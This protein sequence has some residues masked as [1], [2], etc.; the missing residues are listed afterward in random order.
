LQRRNA[1]AI[2]FQ[3]PMIQQVA[4]VAVRTPFWDEAPLSREGFMSCGYWL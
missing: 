1:A 4:G 2:F 3:P